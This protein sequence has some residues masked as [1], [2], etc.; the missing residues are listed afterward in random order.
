MIGHNVLRRAG[1]FTYHDNKVT[2]QDTNLPT[3]I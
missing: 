3:E 1:N 2:E